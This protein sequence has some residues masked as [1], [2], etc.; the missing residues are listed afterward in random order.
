MR[1]GFFCAQND[2]MQALRFQLYELELHHP[3][4]AIFGMV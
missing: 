2:L 3:Q 1:F 4:G